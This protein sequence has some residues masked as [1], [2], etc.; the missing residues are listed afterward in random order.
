MS[1]VMSIDGTARAISAEIDAIAEAP[2]HIPAT[3]TATRARCTL[4]YGD[5][6]VVVDSHGDIGTSTGG[7]D[8]LFHEDTRFLTPCWQAT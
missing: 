3:G 2:F 6:F 7:P 8:G 5:T 4:K 1:D